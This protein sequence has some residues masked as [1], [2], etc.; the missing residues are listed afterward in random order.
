MPRP[1]AELPPE[2]RDL[3]VDRALGYGLLVV[4]KDRVEYPLPREDAP[5]VANEEDEYAEFAGGE[6]QLIPP[7]DCR[8]VL[9][10]DGEAVEVL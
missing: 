6:L 7:Q 10:V 1:V 2:V 3:H 8:T 9:L 4:R 5:P